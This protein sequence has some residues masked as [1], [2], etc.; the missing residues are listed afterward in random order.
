MLCCFD[1]KSLRIYDK[2]IFWATETFSNLPR[3]RFDILFDTR[4]FGSVYLWNLKILVF[5]KKCEP[6]C[7]PTHMHSLQSDGAHLAC[8]DTLTSNMVSG[9]KRSCET[10]LFQ[11][12][13]DLAHNKVDRQTLFCLSKAFDRVNHLSTT[14]T[15]P[16]WLKRKYSV[17]DKGLSDWTL[18]N[19]CSGA[20]KLIRKLC[21]LCGVP[22][23]SVLATLLFLLYKNESNDLHGNIYSQFWLF[24]D[25]TAIYIQLFGVVH[26]FKTLSM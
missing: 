14:Q 2:N 11:L 20:R 8:P 18:S 19:S 5:H 6:V 15:L 21:Q 23:G 10:Q 16:T 9:E 12:V 7:S 26:L 13:E 4:M 22:Q 3:L 25:D 24:A 1:A 17:L